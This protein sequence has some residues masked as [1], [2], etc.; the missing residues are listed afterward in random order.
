VG[1]KMTAIPGTFIF[2]LAGNL[3]YFNPGTFSGMMQPTSLPETGKGP[4]RLPEEVLALFQETRVRLQEDPQKALDRL[5]QALL[6]NDGELMLLRSFAVGSTNPSRVVTH[7]LIMMEQVSRQGEPDLE[8]TAGR[9]GLSRR[10]LEV[11][12]CLLQG[13]TTPRIAEALYISP[14]TVKTHVKHI[15]RKMNVTS[16]HQIITAFMSL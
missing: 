16:R 9:F 6:H 12:R 7:I 4:L 14:Q 1:E 13:L 10:E 5:D 8:K 11:V 15:M 3:L 2:D